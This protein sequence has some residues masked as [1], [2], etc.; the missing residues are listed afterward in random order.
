VA[1][2]QAKQKDGGRSFMC[3]QSS[4]WRKDSTCSESP[5]DFMTSGEQVEGAIPAVPKGFVR[6]V[7]LRRIN[8]PSTRKGLKSVDR[9]IFYIYCGDRV[10]VPDTAGWEPFGEQMAAAM[11][12]EWGSQRIYSV[13][14]TTI[15]FRLSVEKL[16][17]QNPVLA[18]LKLDNFSFILKALSLDQTSSQP[19]SSPAADGDAAVVVPEGTSPRV[20]PARA[21]KPLPGCT[22]GAMRITDSRGE[23]LLSATDCVAVVGIA[24]ILMCKGARN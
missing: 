20:G 16:K 23:D 1:G 3:A 4:A 8:E 6:L 14:R 24:A 9:D 13:R 5:S 12:N 15:A 7:Q 17:M 21:S 11:A 2:V 10:T 18:G 22:P 19:S